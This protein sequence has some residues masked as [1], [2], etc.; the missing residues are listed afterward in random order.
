VKYIT[1]NLNLYINHM[2]RY[3]KTIRYIDLC[4]LWKF[5]VPVIGARYLSIDYLLCIRVK[6][7]GELLSGKQAGYCLNTDL[8]E[9]KDF[10]IGHFES[11]VIY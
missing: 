3:W 6:K 9:G 2:K 7:D 1:S 10:V 8:K 11:K 4:L 5:E